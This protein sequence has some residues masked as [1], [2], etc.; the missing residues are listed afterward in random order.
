MKFNN[1]EALK[2]AISRYI[3]DNEE[4]FGYMDL[5]MHDASY[6]A[7][8]KAEEYGFTREEAND[9]F[10]SWC[11]INYEF[12]KEDLM[13]E[14]DI[15]FSDYCYRLGT[16]SSFYLHDR[17]MI[18]L[19]FSLQNNVSDIIDCMIY[20]N[21]SSYYVITDIGDEDVDEVT[22]EEL[23]DYVLND[24]Y[25]DFMK[26]C[27][28]IKIIYDKIKSF[29]EGQIEYFTE[30]LKF[31]AEERDFEQEQYKKD[32]P[33]TARENALKTVDKLLR[34]GKKIQ[35]ELDKNGDVKLLEITTKLLTD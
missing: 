1:I 8:D 15:D 33:L 4:M 34:T 10:Y 19:A 22:R 13:Y 11:E 28:P 12:F 31:R 23:K 7:Y 26:W 32:C 3:Q 25:Y 2:N 21:Y 30:E 9:I 5:K 6:T 16:T 24:L 27:E 17:S 18:N 35:L 29:K 14:Y 20:D